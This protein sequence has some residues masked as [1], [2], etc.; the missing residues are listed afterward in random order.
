VIVRT[1]EEERERL[2]NRAQRNEAAALA[3]ALTLLSCTKGVVP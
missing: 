2:L 1:M 3:N